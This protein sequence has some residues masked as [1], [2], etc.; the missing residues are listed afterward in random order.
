MLGMLKEKLESTFDFKLNRN[1]LKDLERLSFEIMRRENIT[2]EAL[3]SYLKN[4]SFAA[5]QQGRN[6][7]FALKA[8]LIQYRFPL[9]T[10]RQIID[11]KKVFL[12]KINEPLLDNWQAQKEF[13]PLK[14]FVEGAVKDNYLVDNFQK[15]FPA[16]EIEVINRY[17]EYLKKNKFSLAQL[18]KP[19][20]FIIKEN[21]DFLKP[22]PC[23]KE[24][25][26]CGYWIFNLGFGCPY[27]CSYCFLQQY[28]NFPGIILPANLEDFFEKF[29]NFIKKLT[30]PIRIGTGEFCDSLAL[31]HLTEYSKRLIPYFANK[32]I[33]FELK[34]K[35]ANIANLAT[36]R[37]PKNIVI[38]WSLNPAEIIES[39]EKATANLEERLDAAVKLQNIGYRIA[40]H[41]DPIIHLSGWQNLYRDLIDKIYTKINPPF[42]WISLGTLRS[43]RELKTIVELRF[44]KSSIFYGELFLG[45]DKKLRYPLFLRK[46]IY[47][48]MIKWIRNYDLKTPV[49]LC[50]ENKEIWDVL[51]KELKNTLQIENYILNG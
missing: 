29:D 25:L 23:T 51:D 48:H 3:V 33:F 42:S 2:L 39:E 14:V 41:F 26:S 24:H 28:T 43:H 45:E 30:K 6:K 7:F 38:S 32:N 37:P 47:T 34:T 35:S 36:I 1:Q 19:L 10:Q 16:V 15:Y 40:F 49:Y 22:C 50:M 20:I 46:E 8:A 9:T 18:K 31:D 11:A 17:S 44:P 4:N 27:D 12:N 21:W 5:K 13:K